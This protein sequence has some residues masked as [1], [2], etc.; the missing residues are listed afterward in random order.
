VRH[1]QVAATG[2]SLPRRW[3][4]KAPWWSPCHNIC[5]TMLQMCNNLLSQWLVEVL[6]ACGFASRSQHSS[7]W[8]MHQFKQL[9][10]SWRQ[11]LQD[12]SRQCHC[13]AGQG[14]LHVQG[15]LRSSTWHIIAGWKS[16]LWG[17]SIRH[18]CKSWRSCVCKVPCWS[19]QQ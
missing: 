2:C 19:C 5:T 7:I 1:V 6:A 13:L 18:S 10:P 9:H 3:L 15:R 11:L 4:V 8:R 16:L 14:R 12:M 17:L